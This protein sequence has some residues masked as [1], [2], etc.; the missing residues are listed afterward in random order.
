MALSPPPLN[1][2]PQGLLDWFQ[3]KNGGQN[4][5]YLSNQLQ[6]TFDLVQWYFATNAVETPSFAVP[7]V[8]ANN[9]VVSLL[10]AVNK[11]RY[12]ISMSLAFTP[13]V[14]ADALMGQVKLLNSATLQTSSLF[15]LQQAV[16]CGPVQYDAGFN[17]AASFALQRWTKGFG[18]FWIP[19]GLDVCM[20]QVI[21]TNGGAAVLDVHSRMCN[22]QQ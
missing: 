17:F 10:P 4:P 12:C 1:I 18:N 11:W 2:Q 13:A 14:A 8:T 7:Y 3:I 9:T 6:P 20:V 21:G 16:P 15:P 19:P 22:L 5:Q